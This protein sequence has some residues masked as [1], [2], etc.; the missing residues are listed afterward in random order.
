[1]AVAL[2]DVWEPSLQQQSSLPGT[3][4]LLF[5]YCRVQQVLLTWF[6][7]S[8]HPPLQNCVSKGVFEMT[9]C[10]ALNY[11]PFLAD[12]C[13][14]ANGG[15]QVTDISLVSIVMLTGSGSGI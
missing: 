8:S 5:L 2:C 14:R 4:S 11:K 7:L 3:V 6:L 12:I 15:L 13:S 9:T 1:M 10:S